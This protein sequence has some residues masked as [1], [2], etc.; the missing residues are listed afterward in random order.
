A[1]EIDA[2]AP[3]CPLPSSAPGAITVAATDASG[4]VSVDATL[5]DT[6]GRTVAQLA[7]TSAPAGEQTWTGEIALPDDLKPRRYRLEIRATDA[8]GETSSTTMSFTLNGR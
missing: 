6:T 3:H 2:A 7:P 8:S 5:R 1:P 4:I